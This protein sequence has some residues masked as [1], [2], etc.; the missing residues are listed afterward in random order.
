MA[1]QKPNVNRTED[2][3]LAPGQGGHMSESSPNPHKEATVTE[4]PVRTDQSSET[5]GRNA[6]QTPSTRDGR[7]QPSVAEASE[8]GVADHDSMFNNADPQSRALS[9]S[10]VRASRNQD[11]S[12]HD[13]EKK[14]A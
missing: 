3:P 5:G 10:G 13:K 1:K 2:Q 12:E 6:A 7:L 11:R 9:P 4:M 8:G 14:S